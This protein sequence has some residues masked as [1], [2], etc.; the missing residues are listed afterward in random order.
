MPGPK[1]M[2]I[3]TALIMIGG[4]SGAKAEYSL[5]QLQQLERLILAKNCS[6]LWAYLQQHP[7]IMTGNDPLARELQVFVQSTQRGLLNCFASTTVAVLPTPSVP[8]VAATQS[9]IASVGAAY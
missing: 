8:P 7:E 5:A 1:L 9:F 4:G 6:S 2:A 3:I